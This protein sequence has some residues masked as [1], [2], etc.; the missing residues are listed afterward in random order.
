MKRVQLQPHFLRIWWEIC[1]RESGEIMT[2]EATCCLRHRQ[3]IALQYES[4]RSSGQL[5][6]ACDL[7]EGRQPRKIAA[8]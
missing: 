4:A 2:L 1:H 8:A 7:C 3:E 6:D 5:G